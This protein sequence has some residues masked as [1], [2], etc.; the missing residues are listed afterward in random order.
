MR[1][2]LCFSS[3]TATAAVDDDDD[4]ATTTDQQQ[5]VFGPRP[6]ARKIMIIISLM[7]GVIMVEKEGKNARSEQ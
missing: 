2:S 3:C 4:V 6:G 5:S 1:H 7:L